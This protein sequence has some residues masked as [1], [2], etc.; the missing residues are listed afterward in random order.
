MIVRISKPKDLDRALRLAREP[1]DVIVADEGLPL[2][3]RGPWSFPEVGYIP[4]APQVTLDVRGSSVT[5]TDPETKTNGKPRVDRDLELFRFG[6]GATILGGHWN[7]NHAAFPDWYVSGL[8]CIGGGDYHVEGLDIVGLRGAYKTD[9]PLGAVEVFAISNQGRPG[10]FVIANCRVHDCAPNAYVS[11]IFPGGSEPSD[12]QGQVSNCDVDLSNDNWFAFSASGE[13]YGKPTVVFRG[14]TGSA[15]RG[16]H[17]DTGSTHALMEDCKLT[18]TWAPVTFVGKDP[19]LSRV[20]GLRRCTLTGTLAVEWQDS[21][22][23]GIVFEGCRSTAPRTAAVNGQGALVFSG[24]QL[25]EPVVFEVWANSRK[26][27]VL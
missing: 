21:A 16:F 2:E 13:S 22:Q 10:N 17:N 24:C 15:R 18:G 7:G 23:G 8:R 5:L 9:T 26:P 3:T 19:K 25:V 27:I 11:G 6:A 12:K 20:L 1:G 4:L 14:C